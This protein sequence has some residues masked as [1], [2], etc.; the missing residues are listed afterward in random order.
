MILIYILI[1]LMIAF[2]LQE[3]IYKMLF[4]K[5][6]KSKKKTKKQGSTDGDDDGEEDDGEEDDGEEEPPT[7]EP[8]ATEP[9][10]TEPPATEPPATEPPKPKTEPP[11]P[12]TPTEKSEWAKYGGCC[13]LTDGKSSQCHINGRDTCPWTKGGRG[14]DIKLENP[15][16]CTTLG[17]GSVKDVKMQLSNLMS[18]SKLEALSPKKLRA[19][20]LKSVI[21]PASKKV[22][23]V[24]FIRDQNYSDSKA[25]WVRDSVEKYIVYG[26]K[27]KDGKP[28][29]LIRLN[30]Q[31]DYQ[32]VSRADIR[33]TFDPKSGAYSA[34][35]SDAFM[36]DRNGP[37]MNLGWLDTPDESKGKSES[38]GKATVVIHEF[39]HAL[40]MIH[41][42]NREDAALPWNCTA[43]RKWLRGPP[44]SWCDDQIDSNVFLPVPMM[45]LNASEYDPKSIM[46]YYFP[47][48]FFIPETK[49]PFNSELSY[50][51][52]I[53]LAQTY[54]TGEDIS[55]LVGSKSEEDTSSTKKSNLY[56]II[57][58]VVLGILIIVPIVLFFLNKNKEEQIEYYPSASSEP[59]LPSPSLDSRAY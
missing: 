6:S 10:A 13:V 15:K 31:W 49:L 45:Q 50:L 16:V 8:P 56:G 4:D 12:P 48:D 7:T 55:I 43:V 57:I 58:L 35:G 32:P 34:L 54:P 38:N 44:N 11:K 26:G 41:E 47:P 21:W 59:I 40:G 17:L 24:G 53:W 1:A 18:S 20:F 46:H 5:S 28:A 14:S 39:G 52:K 23:T 3:I 33:I 29:R 42:H 25:K 22:I 30:F 36:F 27:D 9:P 51:D 2:V 37:T 19:A